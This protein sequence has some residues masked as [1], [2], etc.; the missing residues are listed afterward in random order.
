MSNIP[1]VQQPREIIET[2]LHLLTCAKDPT[3]AL[4]F[5]TSI[6]TLFKNEAFLDLLSH[7]GLSDTQ[8]VAPPPPNDN[9][10]ALDEIK[11][12]LSSL[13]KAISGLQTPPPPPIKASKSTPA[14]KSLPPPP[15]KAYLAIATSRTL[16]PSLV[17]TLSHIQTTPE[18]C[19]SL[20]LISTTLNTKLPPLYSQKVHIAAI[21]WTA[22][23]NLIITA[24]P[25]TSSKVLH[26]ASP[27]I[28]SILHK[29]FQQDSSAPLLRSAPWTI[30]FSLV[31]SDCA[32]YTYLTCLPP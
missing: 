9:S 32:Y 16:N 6:T 30:F 23:G 15:K 28:G 29:A 7:N 13:A 11:S 31:D 4:R 26:K 3:T 18:D 12:S 5:S 17:V 19:P 21:R 1:M 20:A 14:K 27:H 22:Q 10:S 2:L 8:E 25:S 24:G